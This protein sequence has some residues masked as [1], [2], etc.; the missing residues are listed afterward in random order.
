[1]N[2]RRIL[3]L[4]V[5]LFAITFTHAQVPQAIS[6]Q[7]VAYDEEGNVLSNKAVSVQLEILQGSIS[8]AVVYQEVH[9]AATSS[10]GV[11]NLRIGQG[12]TAEYDFS[13]IDWS[14]APYFVRLSM[15]TQGGDAYK[16]VAVSQMLSVPYALYA[17][18]AGSVENAEEK[19]IK[20]RVYPR[21][22][23]AAT[24]LT[25]SNQLIS[26]VNMYVDYMDEPDQE[27]QYGIIGLPEGIIIKYDGYS[28]DEEE[29]N[30]G[31]WGRYLKLRITGD[32][33]NSTPGIYNGTFRLW[34]KYGYVR[35]YPFRF[36]LYPSMTVEGD[37]ENSEETETVPDLENP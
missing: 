8:G 6:Y 3:M 19:I 36:E 2:T 17:E 23:G 1:M 24:L 15:D 14:Q 21:N 32:K 20:F 16:E 12:E 13:S 27:V 30:T 25:G 22:G 7:A 28:D 29:E 37:S 35:E 10:N 31:P 4:C 18:K 9:R 5:W 11:L 34:N 33:V 26:N